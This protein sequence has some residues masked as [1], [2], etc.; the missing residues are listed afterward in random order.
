MATGSDDAKPRQGQVNLCHDVLDAMVSRSHIA[1]NAPTGSGKSLAYGVPAMLRAVVAQ[2]RTVIS[3]ESIGLQSQLIEKDLPVVARATKR[4]TGR[5]PSF[6]VLKGWSNYACALAAMGA[7]Q[8]LSDRL[9]SPDADD[10]DQGDAAQ[11]SGSSLIERMLARL[12]GPSKTSGT[13]LTRARAPKTE[14]AAIRWALRESLD[15]DAT[16]DRGA[17]DV[18]GV[19]ASADRVW[20][21][22]STSSGECA[23]DKCP[24]AVECKPRAAR[25]RAAGADVIVTNHS[26]LAVQATKAVPAVIGSKALGPID[27]LVV[28]EAHSLAAVV[29]QQGSAEVGAALISTILRAVEKCSDRSFRSLRT[30]ATDLMKDLDASLSTLGRAKD[31]SVPAD[32]DPF[33]AVRPSLSAWLRSARASV[34]SPDGTRVP[35]EIRRR[36][37][38]QSLISGLTTVMREV[39]DSPMEYARWVEEGRPPGDAPDNLRGLGWWVLRVSPV[40]VAPML[41][42]GVYDYQ[43][44]S[45]PAGRRSTDGST[46]DSDLDLDSGPGIEPD[47]EMSVTAVSATL[48]PPGVV[49]LGLRCRRS[50]YPSPFDDAY[51]RSMLFVPKLS[52]DQVDMLNVAPGGS[53]PRMGTDFH[54]AWALGYIERLVLV[55]GG[56]ALILAATSRA[57]QFYAEGLRKALLGTGIHVYSQWDGGGV[58]QIT[59]LWRADHRSVLV[60]TKSLMTGVD[61][62]GETCSLVVLDRVPRAPRNPVDEARVANLQARLDTDKWS[63]DRM[64]YVA[65]AALLMAQ[66]AGRLI[67]SETDGG[68]VACLDPR[69]LRTSKMAYQEQ[70]RRELIATVDHFGSRASSIERAETFLRD[71]SSAGTP[72]T[73]RSAA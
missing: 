57:G 23:G 2:E 14:T 46:G 25:D 73:K 49:D 20:Q 42:S 7:A 24:Y 12:D 71:R 32:V 47:T 69:L 36:Y 65:D 18:A 27:H 43:S 60:G 30:S 31:S 64:V 37:R 55:N 35:S 45:G 59:D 62:P 28:D 6:A 11:M 39:G 13:R 3:T 34:P 68:M 67:R 29:R 54:P 48:M 40:D 15:P 17:F 26:M 8:E 51:S 41:R 19:G 4:L 63:A 53:R 50:T 21:M 5:Q 33:E 52:A 16:G 61:A 1:G 58:R 56:S 38:A 10:T 44:F 9:G 66:A 72:V 22:L 70:T